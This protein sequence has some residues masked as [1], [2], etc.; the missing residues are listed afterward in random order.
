MHSHSNNFIKDC[1]ICQENI[2]LIE[3]A[4]RRLEEKGMWQRLPTRVKKGEEYVLW[5]CK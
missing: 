1:P 4:G 5:G 2:R 3:D